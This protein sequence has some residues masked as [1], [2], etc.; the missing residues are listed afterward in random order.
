MPQRWK[1]TVEFNGTPF[2]GWQRQDHGPSVQGCLEEAV[3]RFSQEVVTVHAAGRTDSGVHATGMVASF[4]LAKPVSAD[5]VRDALNYH[6][7]P[8]PI[9]VLKAEAMAPDF[10]A[11][12]SCIG[13]SYLYRI[14]NRRAPL[15]LD[16]GRSWLVSHPLDADTMDRAARRLIGRHDFSSFR[17][18]LCQA[19]SPVKTLAE[20]SVTRCGEEVRIVARARSFLHHQVRNM[21]GT[22]KLVGEGRWNADDVSAALAARDRGAAGPTAPADGLY[23]TRACYP[24][25]DFPEPMTDGPSTASSTSG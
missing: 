12:F 9:A 20:L 8:H 7:K 21:V 24:G 1:I 2:L 15:A 3:T 19:A 11:R 16:A 13:R 5:K 6:L 14:T 17:A 25:D 22:L 10:H 23:F 4:D 18:S